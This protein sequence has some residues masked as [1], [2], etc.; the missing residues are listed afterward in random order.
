MRGLEA[1]GI[2][3][4]IEWKIKGRTGRT[5][6]VSKL[7]AASYLEDA[8]TWGEV[9]P[10]VFPNVISPVIQVSFAPF[11]VCLSATDFFESRCC[12]WGDGAGGALG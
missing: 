4:W 10:P 6:Y 7:N 9:I 3:S 11:E 5:P 1:S 12:I 8:R 2:S